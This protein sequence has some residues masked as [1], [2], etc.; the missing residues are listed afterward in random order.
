MPFA[1]LPSYAKHFLVLLHQLD[2][3]IDFC[4]YTIE[5]K[6]WAIY[7]NFFLLMFLITLV[8]HFC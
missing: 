1:R 4:Y 2:T 5:E 7:Q 8:R 3:A 6:T